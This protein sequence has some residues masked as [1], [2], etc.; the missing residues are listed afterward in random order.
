PYGTVTAIDVPLIVPATSIVS[1]GLSTVVNPKVVM[2]LAELAATA[3]VTMY[4]FVEPSAAP[5][6]YWTGPRKLC[7]VT[8]LTCATA[9]TFTETPVVSK[10]ATSALT[11]VPLG[12]VAAI[13]VPLIAAVMSTWSP[14]LSDARNR[15][16]IMSF[17]L[18]AATWTITV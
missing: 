6:V 5:T 12:T 14:G 13:D 11:F 3:I 4:V 15:Y 9:P 2:S 18:F 8:S 10:F 7:R 1:V 17:A 16:D